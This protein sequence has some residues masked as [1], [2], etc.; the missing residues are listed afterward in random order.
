M[1]KLQEEARKWAE[2]YAA[3]AEGKAWQFQDSKGDWRD[4]EDDDRPVAWP[5]KRLR[6]KPES[7]KLYAATWFDVNGKVCLAKYEDAK[8]LIVA[9]GKFSGFKIHE[10]DC[11]E[12]P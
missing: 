7:V 11:G 2:L 8:H 1:T 3:I 9:Y 5:V 10:L 12:A 6:I 4:S